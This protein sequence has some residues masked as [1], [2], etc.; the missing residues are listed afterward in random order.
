MYPPRGLERPSLPAGHHNGIESAS[1]P[2]TSSAP[3]TTAPL[4]IGMGFT[5]TIDEL[6]I[7]EKALTAERIAALC[8]RAPQVIGAEWLVMRQRV[9]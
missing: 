3:A 5:G 1:E 8:G 6:A 2:A 4:A 7:Y 9:R